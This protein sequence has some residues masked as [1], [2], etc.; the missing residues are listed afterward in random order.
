MKNIKNGLNVN[1]F[2]T[3]KKH[4]E[5]NRPLWNKLKHKKKQTGTY[6]IRN[7]FLQLYEQV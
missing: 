7:R 3:F 5:R 2:L 6:S 4:L 1:K